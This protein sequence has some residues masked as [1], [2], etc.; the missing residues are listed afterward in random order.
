MRAHTSGTFVAREYDERGLFQ[1][2]FTRAGSDQGWNFEVIP[3]PAVAPTPY[4]TSHGGG[5]SSLRCYFF[6]RE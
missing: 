2:S 1:P 3:P 4:E 5:A 6:E